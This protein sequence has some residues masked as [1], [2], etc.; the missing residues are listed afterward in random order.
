MIVW[1]KIYEKDYQKQLEYQASKLK[2]KSNKQPKKKGEGFKVERAVW[3]RK[4]EE[5]NQC[6]PKYAER[7]KV[8]LGN[9]N[10]TKI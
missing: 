4:A 10:I 2:V 9:F 8:A 6:H 3:N 1:H 5:G 7:E